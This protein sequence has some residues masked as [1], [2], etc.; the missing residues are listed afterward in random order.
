MSMDE[1]IIQEARPITDPESRV[2]SEA[3]GRRRKP[4]ERLRADRDRIEALDLTVYGYTTDEAQGLRRFKDNFEQ[5]VSASGD[6]PDNF[7]DGLQED[8]IIIAR[9]SWYFKSRR[10]LM[11]SIQHSIGKTTEPFENALFATRDMIQKQLA[12]WGLSRRT[13]RFAYEELE[14]LLQQQWQGV[15][16]FNKRPDAKSKWHEGAHAIQLLSGLDM[17]ASDGVT[18]LKRE[19]EVNQTLL[20]TA[21]KGLLK[22]IPENGYVGSGI[23]GPFGEVLSL[24]PIDIYHEVVYFQSNEEE[25]NKL[26]AVQ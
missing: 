5:R 3:E 20:Q 2:N 8:G 24:S 25:I 10:P 26:S 18:R 21:S 6:N 13:N 1:S 4:N 16:F 9:N 7:L 15:I 22:D 17:D 19:M 12:N 14:L 23:R 11:Q